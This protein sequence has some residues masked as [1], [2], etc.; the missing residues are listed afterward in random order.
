MVKEDGMRFAGVRTPQ[1]D[2]VCLLNFLIRTCTS[3]HSKDCR[4]TDDTRG[5]SS[6]VAAVDVVAAHNGP[7]KFLSCIVQFVGCLGATENSKCLRTMLLQ[8]HSKPRHC[9]VESLI[10]SCRL[11]AAVS[12]NHRLSE[13]LT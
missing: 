9:P 7:S 5:V 12:P 13:P 1:D 4:Q 11:Q 2:E 6:T 10:P 8:S 3:A